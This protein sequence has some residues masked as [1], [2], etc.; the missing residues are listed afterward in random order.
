[1]TAGSELDAFLL[2]CHTHQSEPA[3]STPTLTSCW[4]VI[5][6]EVCTWVPHRTPK[7][8]DFSA[9]LAPWEARHP[10]GEVPEQFLSDLELFMAT[11]ARAASQGGGGEEHETSTTKP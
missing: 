5:E 11:H 3:C 7:P 10:R 2:R 4:R 6:E 8:S 9:E 1:M